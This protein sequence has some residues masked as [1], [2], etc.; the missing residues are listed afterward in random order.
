MSKF[1]FWQS[2]LVSP[3]HIVLAV[4]VGRTLF[5][6]L[7]L[8]VIQMIFLLILENCLD[9]SDKVAPVVLLIHENW[10]SDSDKVAAE[11]RI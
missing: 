2:I 5:E 7:A 10:L 1:A 9:D 3:L 11:D 6:M 8:L 4:S